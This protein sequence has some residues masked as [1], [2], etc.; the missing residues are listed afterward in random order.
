MGRPP[1]IENQNGE[2]FKRVV[3]WGFCIAMPWDPAF[4]LERDALFE[5][6]DS[7]FACVGG[8]CSAYQC[9]HHEMLEALSN[10]SNYIM[11]S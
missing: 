1:I 5:E 7:V 3:L 10:S 11:N 8:G 2:F 6:C 9:Q 4:E